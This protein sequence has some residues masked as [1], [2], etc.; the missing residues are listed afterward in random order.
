MSTKFARSLLSDQTRQIFPLIPSSPTAVYLDATRLGRKIALTGVGCYMH[1]GD[2]YYVAPPNSSAR[3]DDE[4]Y[5]PSN[6]DH[7]FNSILRG[8]YEPRIRLRNGYLAHDACWKILYRA[9]TADL[10]L[11]RLFNLLSFLPDPLRT[12]GWDCLVNWNNGCGGVA[13]EM[14]SSQYPWQ[15]SSC[16][17]RWGVKEYYHNPFDIRRLQDALTQDPALPPENPSPQL[18]TQPR[19]ADCFS[20]LPQEVILLVAQE[21]TT[22]DFFQA[23]LASRSFGPTYHNQSFWLS[24]FVGN[25]E[26]AS[27]VWYFEAHERVQGRDWRHLYRQTH[28]FHEH[29]TANRRR[30]WNLAKKILSQVKPTPISPTPEE[31]TDVKPCDWNE[32]HALCLEPIMPTASGTEN[33]V[34]SGCVVYETFLTISFYFFTLD[35]SEYLC[36]VEFKNGKDEATLIGYRAAIRRQPESFDPSIFR[37]FTTAVDMRGIK[38]IRV[39]YMGSKAS[40]WLGSPAKCVHTNSAMTRNQVQMIKVTLDVRPQG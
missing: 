33:L 18:F 24:R 34:H 6:Y 12:P 16:V 11:E 27:C 17:F 9:S 7:S 35:R 10:D 2:I 23:R 5:D 25:P 39:H 28:R 37:G 29:I 13:H 21:L 40:D 31:V 26:V 14:L 4:G 15:Q 36:G 8:P 1:P 19:T 22:R 32:A 3:W 20:K 30:V 38:A